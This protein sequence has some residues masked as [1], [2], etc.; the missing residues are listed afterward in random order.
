MGRARA[1]ERRVGKECR[2]RWSPYNDTATTE[3]YTLSLHDVSD[4]RGRRI[5]PETLGFSLFALRAPPDGRAN[6]ARPPR[7]G[8]A[9]PASSNGWRWLE[10]S[11]QSGGSPRF[12][13]RTTFSRDRSGYGSR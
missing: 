3:I 5:I 7:V 12:R 9:S 11:L 6:R 1:E 2:S 10:P 13:C 8:G 4:L